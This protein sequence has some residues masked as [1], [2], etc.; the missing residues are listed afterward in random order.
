M[1]A[2]KNHSLWSG[3]A[4]HWEFVG[5]PQRPCANDIQLFT[6]IIHAHASHLPHPL[7]AGLMGVTPEL[8]KLNW[9]K[10]TQLT[11]F[12]INQ[13]MIDQLWTGN[14]TIAASV[15]LA[16]WRALP[17]PTASLDLVIGDGVFTATG[18]LGITQAIFA[19]LTRVLRPQ[20]IFITRCFLRPAQQEPLDKIVE[21]AAQG[22]ID[23][24]GTLKWRLAMAL[25]HTE[26]ACATPLEVLDTFNRLFPNRAVLAKQLDCRLEEIN[27]IDAYADFATRLLFQTRHEFMDAIATRFQLIHAQEPDYALGDRCPIMVF[28]P[29]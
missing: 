3:Q 2:F 12:D 26:T 18:S 27:T 20:G 19:E 11:A 25:A 13:K 7:S 29:V 28:K 24:F 15:Q 9:P 10:N 6:E 8:V 16:D 22:Q 17:I 5:S 21:D 1:D 14:Q 23:T 4:N